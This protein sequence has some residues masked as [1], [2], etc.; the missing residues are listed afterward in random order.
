MFNSNQG[1]T[2]QVYCIT[3][4]LVCYIVAKA[5]SCWAQRLIG[6]QMQL[7]AP[8]DYQWTANTENR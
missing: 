3:N 6:Q 7:K 5:Q 4:P 8:W 1:T 2:A